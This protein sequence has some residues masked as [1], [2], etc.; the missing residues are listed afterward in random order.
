MKA[1]IR[2]TSPA[3]IEDKKKKTCEFCASIG[4]DKRHP[5]AQKMNFWTKHSIDAN[6]ALFEQMIIVSKSYESQLSN[7]IKISPLSSILRKL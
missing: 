1:E 4:S 3:S 5:T 6:S 2:K 7:D